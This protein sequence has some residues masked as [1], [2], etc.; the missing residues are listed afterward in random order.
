MHTRGSGF[1]VGCSNS[2]KRDVD[3]IMWALE[4][5][6]TQPQISDWHHKECPDQMTPNKPHELLCLENCACSFTDSDISE[7]K[8]Y[9]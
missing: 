6:N 5:D 4:T 3:G 9:S 1:V 8:H 2:C 7:A